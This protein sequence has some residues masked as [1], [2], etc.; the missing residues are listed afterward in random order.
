MKRSALVAVNCA[1]PLAAA[2]ERAGSRDQLS[3]IAVRAVG[4]QGSFTAAKAELA[5]FVLSIAKNDLS[6]GALSPSG[7]GLKRP[8]PKVADETRTRLR[9]GM[10]VYDLHEPRTVLAFNQGS[11]GGGGT[12]HNSG[13]GA[14]RIDGSG[15]AI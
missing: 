9:A 14:R 8:Y 13:L 5:G 1:L 12:A 15:I 11:R 6:A 3:S 10:A 2:A 7:A 4:V